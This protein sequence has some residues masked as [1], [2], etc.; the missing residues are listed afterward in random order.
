MAHIYC[1]I[2]LKHG[3]FF[4]WKTR[5]ASC[6]SLVIYRIDH[7][8][9]C[10]AGRLVGFADCYAVIVLADNATFLFA[11][12]RMAAFP[13]DFA[14]IA[15]NT[16]RGRGSVGRASAA[17]SWGCGFESQLGQDFSTYLCP[18]R[19][20]RSV[21]DCPTLASAERATPKPHSLNNMLGIH[22]CVHRQ[23]S[24]FCKNYYLYNKQ[25][26]QVKRI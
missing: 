16:T 3:R 20:T 17:Y 18:L 22:E 21:R 1:L 19:H 6:A 12:N 25:I 13:S 2:C 4:S 11:L 26:V 15:H 7:D 9:I 8:T 5:K 23:Q 10:K 24:T 14:I